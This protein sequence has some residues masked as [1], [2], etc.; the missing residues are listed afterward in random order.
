MEAAI[1]RAIRSGH[2][3]DHLFQ[4]ATGRDIRIK[5]DAGVEDTLQLIQ[6]TVPKTLWQ[7]EKI[8]QELRGRTLESTCRNIWNFVYTHIRYRKDKAGTEQVRSPRRTWQDRAH[9][10]DCDCYTEFISSILMNLGIAHKGRITIYDY[11]QGYQHIY[12]IVPKHGKLNTKMENRDEYI[13]IDCVKDAFDDEEPFIE[14]KDY[15]MKLEYLD[16]FGHVPSYPEDM[17]VREFSE[18]NDEAVG[19]IKPGAAKILNVANAGVRIVNRYVNPA[20]VLLRN[21]FL[22]AMKINLLKVAEKIRFAYL[23]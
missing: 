10:V 5:N 2:E 12:P 23:T 15:N 8:A 17:D 22:G 21:G 20:T 18:L 16:G 13:V 19:E 14:F 7:T 1:H 9:G 4:K 3:Y 6:S 11:A